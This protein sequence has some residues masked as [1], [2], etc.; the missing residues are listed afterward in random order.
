MMCYICEMRFIISNIVFL[1]G[2]LCLQTA[3]GQMPPFEPRDPQLYK[4]ILHMDS[5][6]F[7]AFNTQDL[8]TLKTV[9]ADNLEF[10]HDNGG[11]IDYKACIEGFKKMFESHTSNP[12]RRELVKGTLE[13]YPIPGYGAIEMGV[14]RFIHT[15]NGR[16]VIG[17]YKFVHTWQLNGKEWKATRVVSVGH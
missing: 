3:K 8:T 7:D 11:L 5:V 16:Q 17:V 10:Y 2:T 6:M 15:E 14:H 4:V 13:V 9:F 1:L 12:L